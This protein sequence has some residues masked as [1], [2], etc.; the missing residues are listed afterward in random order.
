MQNSAL[1]P[2]SLRSFV[3]FVIEIVFIVLPFLEATTFRFNRKKIVPVLTFVHTQAIRCFGVSGIGCQPFPSY[4]SQ[5]KRR[6]VIWSFFYSG[7]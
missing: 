6:G 2:F 5:V 4:L 7:L 3:N 1:I